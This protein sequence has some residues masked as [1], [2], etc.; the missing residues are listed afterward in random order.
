ML[1]IRRAGQRGHADHGWLDTH[2]TFSFAD[3]YDPRHMGFRALRVINDD[4]V[5]PGRGF[6]M[7][8]HRDMEIIT[9]VLSGSLE[10]RD[11]MGNGA[12]L[13][14]GE[15]QRITAGRGILH[16]EFNPDAQQPVHLYQIWLTPARRG[17][18]PSYEQKAFAPEQKRGRLL[19]VA[20]PD[21]EHGPLTIQQ[22]ARV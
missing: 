8:P 20:S 1:Q 4:V 14:A 7:H 6:G 17:L 11:S 15:L 21:G 10:H 2:Y 5:Q 12:V 9:Y 3:Y 19:L 22:D 13:R 18:E 16:S